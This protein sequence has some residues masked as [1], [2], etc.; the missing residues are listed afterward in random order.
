MDLK[1]GIVSMQLGGPI[2]FENRFGRFNLTF[3]QY[4]TLISD[5]FRGT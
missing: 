5:E 4:I 3:I 1:K 2:D